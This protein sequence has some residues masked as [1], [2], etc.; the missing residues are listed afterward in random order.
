[1]IVRELVALLGVKTDEKGMKKAESS[2]GKLKKLVTGLGVAFGGLAAF[3]WGKNAIK[4][5]SDA[6]ENLNVIDTSFGA[7]AD[8]VMAWAD[9]FD[10]VAGR[11]KY[12][13]QKMAATFGAI[14]NPMLEGNAESAAEL[15]TKLS[16]LTVDLASF[17]NTTESDALVALRAGITGEVEPLKRFGIVMNEAT[18]NAYALEQGITKSVRTMTNAEKTTL[19]YK[20]ILDQTKTAQGDA[21]KTAS[22][23][24]NITKAL[25]AR[26]KD[27]SVTFGLQVNPALEKFIPLL[28]D[29]ADGAIVL[30]KVLGGLLGTLIR[31]VAWIIKFATNLPDEVKILLIAAA[32]MKW[33]KSLSF[34]LTPTGQIVLAILLLIAVI[35]DLQNWVNGGESAFKDMFD[36][37]GEFLGIDM[38]GP[39]LRMLKWFQ[40]L[41]EDPK[42]GFEELLEVIRLIPYMFGSWLPALIEV[43][44]KIFDIVSSS[45]TIWRD[46]IKDVFTLG[47]TQALDNLLDNLKDWVDKVWSLIGDLFQALA[48]LNNWLGRK[49]TGAEARDEKEKSDY[50]LA[51]M[52]EAANSDYLMKNYA[53]KGGG[54]NSVFT[55]NSQTRIDMVI[56]P[57]PG[58]DEK[59]LAKEAVKGFEDADTKRK[60]RNTMNALVPQAG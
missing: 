46:F 21:V 4:D 16:E 56:K 10:D 42:K 9:T 27:L 22:G 39:V 31:T 15:S 14:L 38:S 24:A 35:E 32:I 36:W 12:D 48:K 57:T 23:Y 50:A 3:N 29:F 53:K 55:D 41:A 58:M 7:S 52:S 33:G 30:F 49:I 8:K 17:Y 6:K 1:M 28:I 2:F 34:L 13:L 25:D 43:D 20:F 54:N 40:R 51:Q 11:S 60:Y 59:K 19:R 37:W 26:I 45:F 47:F 5:A 18:L 44:K